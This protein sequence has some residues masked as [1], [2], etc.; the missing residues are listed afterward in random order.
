MSIVILEKTKALLFEGSRKTDVGNSDE[1]M[2]NNLDMPHQQTLHLIPGQL[3]YVL[4]KV[5][6][7]YICYINYLCYIGN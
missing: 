5:L 3:T 7:L 4:L 2:S 6:F 1:S